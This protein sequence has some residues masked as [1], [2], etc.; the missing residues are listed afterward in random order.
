DTKIIN[1][2]KRVLTIWTERCIYSKEFID[3]LR[4]LLNDEN[5]KLALISKIVS[6]YSLKDVISQ[7]GNLSKVEKQTQAKKE[8]SLNCPIDILNNDLLNKLKDKSN[9]EQFNQEFEEAAKS[10]RLIIDAFDK[11]ILA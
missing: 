5:S 7:I 9:G 1:A 4:A 2:I 6:D 10:F 11:E 3:E 8:S